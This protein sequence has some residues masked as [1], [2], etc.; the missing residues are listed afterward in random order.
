MEGEK[1]VEKW[2]VFHEI[3]LSR[4]KGEQRKNK[5]A[6]NLVDFEAGKTILDIAMGLVRNTNK[7]QT[8]LF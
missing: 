5:I 3:D 2:C 8:S 6:R 7:E 4:Y 1:E